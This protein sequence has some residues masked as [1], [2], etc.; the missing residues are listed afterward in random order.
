MSDLFVG[1][2]VLTFI[3]FC[4]YE[5]K[6]K[7]TDLPREPQDNMERLKNYLITRIRSM[8]LLEEAEMYKY[9]IKDFVNQ[10]IF[11]PDIASAKED[12]KNELQAQV[13]YLSVPQLMNA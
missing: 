11:H 12:L 1:I 9:E 8:Q 4:L 13:N 5:G 6:E 10:F 3:A 2:A 7:N